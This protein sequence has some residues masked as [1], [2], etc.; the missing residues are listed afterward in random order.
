MQKFFY[1]NNVIIFPYL[2]TRKQRNYFFKPINK[3][4]RPMSDFFIKA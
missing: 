3:K 1:K 2:K 4:I